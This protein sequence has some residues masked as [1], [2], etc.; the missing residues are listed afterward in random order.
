MTPMM[1]HLNPGVCFFVRTQ[2]L[3]FTDALP[4]WPGAQGQQLRRPING[5]VTFNQSGRQCAS[6]VICYRCLGWAQS[7]MLEVM[8]HLGWLVIR[9]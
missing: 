9:T 5:A 4:D 6:S 7:S 8:P 3:P 1:D 2:L